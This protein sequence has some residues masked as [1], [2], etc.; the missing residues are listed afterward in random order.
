MKTRRNWKAYNSHY[1]G[2]FLYMALANGQNY[3]IGALRQHRKLLAEDGGLD[4]KS[5]VEGW[6]NGVRMERET[7]SREAFRKAGASEDMIRRT[8][9]AALAKAATMGEM[10]A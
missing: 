4:V 7:R 6:C 10:A 8:A 9:R 5:Y 3:M 2:F 1:V